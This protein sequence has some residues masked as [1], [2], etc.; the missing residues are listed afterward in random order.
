MVDIAQR[1]MDHRFAGMC[2]DSVD[3][4]GRRDPECAACSALDALG[5]DDLEWEY[6]W[7]SH[8]S[9]GEEYERLAC[10]SRDQAERE[11][12]Q[13]QEKRICWFLATAT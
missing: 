13:Y 1:L 7:R 12:R 4:W 11:I 3:G 9:N 6:G 8:F 2:P 5:A 10:S